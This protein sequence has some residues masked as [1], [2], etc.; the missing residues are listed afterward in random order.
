MR[1]TKP[2]KP[3]DTKRHHILGFREHRDR[4]AAI[5][6]I[7]VSREWVMNTVKLPDVILP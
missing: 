4:I 1:L 6:L 5:G 3:T 7:G 2:T